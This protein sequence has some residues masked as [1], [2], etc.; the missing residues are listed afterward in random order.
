MHMTEVKKFNA[1]GIIGIIGAL[2]MIIGVF[3]SWL[4]F[5]YSGPLIGSETIS[6][7]GMD[8][9]STDIIGE[10]ENSINFSDIT[11]YYYVPVIALVCGILSLI[12][13]IVP[14]VFN[15]GK[16][17]K[18]LGALAL[19]L[20]VVTLV[21]AFLYYGDVSGYSFNES[22]FGFSASLSIGTG[23]W[24]VIAGSIITV[25]GGIL[26]IAKKSA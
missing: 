2:L 14:T 24:V 4:D 10:G 19:I 3:L 20:A 1:L 8:I 11:D 7:T 21:L 22:L 25:L 12:L 18:I 23:L 16:I 9:F 5:S 26:D 6:Y 13:T 15:K 17:G